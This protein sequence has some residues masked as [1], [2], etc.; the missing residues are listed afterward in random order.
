LTF[1]LTT[2]AALYARVGIPE[3][4]VID[5]QGRRV[6]AHRDPMQ[7]G[8]L[9]VAAYA[10][11]ESLAPLSRPDASLRVADLLPPANTDATQADAHAEP[12]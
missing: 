7:G 1:D 10:E 4:W 2:K 11:T 6:V 12:I 3:Y 5:V 8:Y 9:T